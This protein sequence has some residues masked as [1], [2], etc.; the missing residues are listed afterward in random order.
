MIVNIST[1]TN[2]SLPFRDSS[3]GHGCPFSSRQQKHFVN[4]PGRR[5]SS[6][7]FRSS[8]LH[9]VFSWVDFSCG[10]SCSQL[11][12]LCLRHISCSVP[13]QDKLHAELPEVAASIPYGSRCLFCD[14]AFQH[15][16]WNYAS[17]LGDRPHRLDSRGCLCGTCFALS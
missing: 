10:F 17:L 6:I 5:R 9:L 12:L 3:I 11:V 4:D 7:C 8:L 15:A 14:G 2:D 13:W 16:G 1:P